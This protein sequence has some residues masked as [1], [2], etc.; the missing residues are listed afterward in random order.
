M[1]I[2]IDLFVQQYEQFIISDDETIDYAFAR[3]NTIVTSL[4]ALDESF[5]SHELIG[6]LKVYEVVLEKDSEAYKKKKEKY[7]SLSLKAKKVSS[8]EEASCSDS[9]DEEYAMANFR[10]AK[11]E[12]KGKEERRLDNEVGDL[13]KRLERLEKNKEI[14]VECKSCIDLRTKI[15]SLSL[16]LAKFENSSHFLQEMIE[17]QRLQKDKKDLGFT[18][19]KASTTK[20]KGQESTKVAYEESAHTVPSAM[21]PSSENAGYR[22]AVSIKEAIEPILQN[23]SEFVQVTKKTLP[24]VTIGNVK[25]TPALKLGQGLGKSKIQTRPK[26]P[27]RRPNTLY[28]K[29]DYHQVGWNSSSQQ[30]YHIQ[31]PNFGSWGPYPLYPYM[32]QPNN[33]FNANRPMRYWG[34]N[35]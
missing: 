26:T 31:P 22:R 30:G 14:S 10:R 35:A 11:E 9:D 18:K 3:F 4:K 24:S 17:N 23:R 33:M 34:P 27:L 16:K 6:N 7:K 2:K 21:V 12:K 29:S 15:D 13:K 25:Q 5:S 20:V 8:D 28:P 19:D 32:N 1:T